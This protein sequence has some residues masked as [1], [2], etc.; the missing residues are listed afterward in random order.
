MNLH[1]IK[2]LGLRELSPGIKRI[3]NIPEDKD[4]LTQADWELV[5]RIQ[6]ECDMT[7]YSAGEVRFGP[8]CGM[9]PGQRLIRAYQ[10]GLLQQKEEI[11]RRK[12]EAGACE[13]CR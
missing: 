12:R 4:C 1:R 8:H 6:S 7:K 5:E 10:F 3:L 2:L 13:S 9:S 11:V